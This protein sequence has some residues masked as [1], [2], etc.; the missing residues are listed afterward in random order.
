MKLSI[1][2][3][4]HN[5]AENLRPLYEEL[6]ET[7]DSLSADFEIITVDD[8]S[9]DD[10]GQ[11]LDKLSGKD[12]RVRVIHM[13]NNYG[14]STSMMA[15]FDHASGDVIVAIDGDNQNDPKDIPRLLAKIEEGFDVVS[16]W[17]KDRKDA[18]F[19][20]IIPSKIANWL[21]SLISGVKLHDYGCSLKA[22]RKDVIKGIKLYGELHRFI[23]ILSAGRGA[24]VSEIV[25]GHRSR[26]HGKSHYGLSRVMKVL[27]DLI[28]IKYL[29]KYL[30]HPI[31]F[32]GG[33]G[34]ISYL[35]AVFTFAW[36][37]YY[38]YWEDTTFIQTPL[39][40]LAVLFILMGTMAI[41]MGILAEIVMRTYYESQNKKTYRVLRSVNMEP[42]PGDK[43]GGIR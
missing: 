28:L 43:S 34:L 12:P 32:F 23:P 37:V 19:T 35:L 14:Q 6:A 20:K 18:R 26:K 41:L 16:G 1:I 11:I 22:Y 7:L 29:D 40:T 39:P 10:S 9:E 21:I 5:E 33:F 4:V 2:I 30:Q 15:G 36:M 25:V 17:R 27:L 38:K 3:P 13:M 31:H 42:A 24:K 8:G